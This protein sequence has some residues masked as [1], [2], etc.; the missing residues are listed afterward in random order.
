M[1][2]AF[3]WASHMVPRLLPAGLSLFPFWEAPLLKGWG[4]SRWGLAVAADDL[5]SLHPWQ[6]LREDSTSSSNAG[7]PGGDPGSLCSL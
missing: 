4:S 6:S 5:S 3:W 1:A 7:S 2:S